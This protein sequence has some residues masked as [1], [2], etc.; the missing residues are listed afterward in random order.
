MA[1]PSYGI[2]LLL[3]V[4]LFAC[5]GTADAQCGFYRET[6]RTCHDDT[7]CTG[8]RKGFTPVVMQLRFG[9]PNHDALAAKREALPIKGR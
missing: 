6:S 2:G 8:S 1:R 3:I 4:V 9:E 5:V 7:G